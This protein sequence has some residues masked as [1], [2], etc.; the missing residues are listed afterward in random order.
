M[1][2]GCATLEVSVYVKML[3]TTQDMKQVNF[4][5]KK[6]KKKQ[7]RQT[8]KNQK[9]KKKSNKNEQNKKKK[10]ISFCKIGIAQS[11]SKTNFNYCMK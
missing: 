1:R 4:N 3:G 5:K 7:Q 6:Q 2:L 8:N 11:W 10:N 9:K